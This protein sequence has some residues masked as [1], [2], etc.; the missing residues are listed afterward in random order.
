MSEENP[1]F[2]LFVLVIFI[3]VLGIATFQ[4]NLVWLES[5]SLWSDAVD[6][7]PGKARPHYNYAVTLADKGDFTAALQENLRA[8]DINP[9]LGKAYFNVGAIYQ[10][11]GDVRRSIDQYR[12]AIALRPDLALSHNNLGYAYYTLGRRD[13]AKREYDEAIRLKPDYVMAYINR[14]NLQME[15]NRASGAAADY[16]SAINFGGNS[17]GGD[18]YYRLAMAFKLLNRPG[19]AREA[20]LI[21]IRLEPGLAEGYFEL[22]LMLER[23]GRSGEASRLYRQALSLD[24]SLENARERLLNI[25]NK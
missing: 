17:L 7:S 6:K 3:S 4:R 8:L 22:G 12:I 1:L 19:D 16:M 5:S 20:L 23:E 21:S 13:E 18:V 24:P 2:F 15:L 14:A 25:Y 10:N 11:R 9:L